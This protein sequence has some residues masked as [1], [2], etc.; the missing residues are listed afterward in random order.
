M[1]AGIFNPRVYL[2]SQ[3]LL[4]GK[5]LGGTLVAVK[6]S[7]DFWIASSLVIIRFPKRNPATTPQVWLLGNS[8]VML[9]FAAILALEVN[10]CWDFIRF[11]AQES[12][13]LTQ[14]WMS[15]KFLHEILPWAIAPWSIYAALYFGFVRRGWREWNKTLRKILK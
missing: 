13:S 3:F 6:P 10:I 12:L 11:M 1:D 9:F 7:E 14:A 2:Q 8:F 4:K 15:T 5:W